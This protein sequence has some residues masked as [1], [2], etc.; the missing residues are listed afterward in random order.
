M[1]KVITR[2][3]ETLITT[4]TKHSKEVIEIIKKYDNIL[5]RHGFLEGDFVYYY[6]KYKYYRPLLRRIQNIIKYFL[7]PEKTQISMKCVS[8]R[9]TLEYLEMKKEY[10]EHVFC[11]IKIGE[12]P[13]VF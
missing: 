12:S 1:A 5:I 13:C 6:N 11:N 2:Y 10:P 8:K 3:W 9:E 7:T 4:G